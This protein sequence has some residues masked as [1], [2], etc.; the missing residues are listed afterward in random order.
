MAELIQTLHDLA[1]ICCDGEA[2]YRDVAA[3]IQDSALRDAVQEVGRVR[4]ALC[5]DFAE[6]LREQGERPS[7]TGTVYGSLHKL[8]AELRARFSND[9]DRIY[10]AE[11]EEAEDRLLSAMEVALLKLEPAGAREVV[12]RYMP[13]ARTAHERMRE[14]KIKVTE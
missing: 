5:H 12:R 4:G 2:F 1:Q 13:A 6:C 9:A 8:Y 10:V 14:L 11:L 3:K 7:G